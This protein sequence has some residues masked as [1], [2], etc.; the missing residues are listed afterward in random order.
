MFRKRVL[1]RKEKKERKM[2]YFEVMMFSIGYGV[3]TGLIIIC[4]AKFSNYIVEN[5]YRQCKHGGNI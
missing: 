2:N 4:L 5:I 1:R 3:I